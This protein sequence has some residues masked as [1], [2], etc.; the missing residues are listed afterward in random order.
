MT[1]KRLLETQTFEKKAVFRVKKFLAYFA[2]STE[3][4]IYQGKIIN[5]PIGFPTITMETI[6]SILW[7]L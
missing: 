6:R 3:N 1:P 2:R 7:D 4:D 5:G